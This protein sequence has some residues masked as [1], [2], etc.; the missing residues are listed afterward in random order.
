[1]HV[2]DSKC[3]E[4]KDALT[5]SVR[6]NLSSA[7]LLSGGLDSSIL[8]SIAS[9]FVDLTG[10]TVTYN[11]APDL[12]Y[13]K[14]IAVKHSIKHVIKHLTIDDMEE[15]AQNVIRIMQSFDPMEVR[16]TAVIYSSVNTL[17]RNGFDSVMTGDG[18]DELFVGYNYLLRL[19]QD[20]LEDEIEKLWKIMHFSSTKIGHELGVSVRSPFLDHEFIEF[21]KK[22]PVSLKVREGNGHRWGKWILRSCFQSEITMQIAWRSKMPLEHGAGTSALTQ[23]FN[24]SISD[25]YFNNKAKICAQKD[26]VKIRDKEHLRY[27]EIYSK[28]FDAPKENDCEARCP[29]CQGCVEKGSR[30][31]NTCGAFPIKPIH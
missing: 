13:A 20:R 2:S 17:K 7:V 11:S 29:D 26:S 6:R 14:I 1:M 15:A 25:D 22:I 19:D 27:Y 12:H 10:I 4:L 16:N 30:F 21:A 23:H 8:A 9:E 18:G 31:C 5:A 28:F 3:I 24:S